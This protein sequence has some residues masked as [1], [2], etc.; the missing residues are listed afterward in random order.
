[1]AAAILAAALF[2]PLETSARS[3]AAYK[4]IVKHAYALKD[5]KLFPHQLL[6]TY[7]NKEFVVDRADGRMLGTLSSALWETVKVLDVG[8]KEQSFK[9]I[10]VSGGYV[11]VR[12]L[13]IRE[14]DTSALKDFS[15]AE[16]DDVLAGVCTHLD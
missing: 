5:G 3:S 4:C 16:N 1:M 8:S 7:V 9:A 11:Q 13:I 12:L 15:I 14:F 10:Y 6:S 2:Q